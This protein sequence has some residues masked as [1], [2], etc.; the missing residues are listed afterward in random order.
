MP[1]SQPLTGMQIMTGFH[2]IRL[3]L[4]REPEHPH[5]DPRDGWDLVA[6]LD[7]GGR[8]DLA[9]VRAAPSRCRVRRFLR[10]ETFAT[11]LLRRGPSDQWMLDLD[12]HEDVSGFRF[13][14][15]RFVLGEYV[16]ITASSGRAQTYGV[17]RLKSLE[18][19]ED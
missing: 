8:L 12:R 2:H 18:P 9:A 15:E 19:A 4:A 1:S 5:G 13:G 11:G 16:S 6:P 3:E 10:G 14:E 7:D 17:E